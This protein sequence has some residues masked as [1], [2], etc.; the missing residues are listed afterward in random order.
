MAFSKLRSPALRFRKLQPLPFVRRFS[1]SSPEE[2]AAERRRRRSLL[3]MPPP[4]PLGDIPAPPPPGRHSAVK[5]KVNPN[6]PNLPDSDAAL[7]GARLLFHNNILT[8]IRSGDLQEADLLVRHSIYSNCRP[9]IFT[10]NTVLS[11]LLR[12][13]L[14]SEFLSLHRFVNQAGIAPTVFT[15]NLVMQCYIDRSQLDL[16]VDHYRFFCRSLPLLPSPTTY[17]VLVK[18]LVEASRLEEALQLKEEMIGTIDPDPCVY[19]LLMD[20]L[21]DNGDPDRALA[22]YD[23]LKEKLSN[24][25]PK[26]LVGIVNGSL[27]RAH[28]KKGDEGK[29]MQVY[30]SVLGDGSKFK[31]SAQ[32][33]N[34]ILN[35]LNKNGKFEEALALFDRMMGEHCPP[36]RLAMDLESFNIMVDGYCDAG[37]FKEAIEVFSKMREKNCMSDAFSYNNLIKQLGK[38]GMVAEAVELYREMRESGIKPNESTFVF[39]MEAF[40]VADRV[41]DAT[42]YLDEMVEVGVD[43]GTSA[44]NAAFSGLVNAGKLYEAKGYF[45]RMMEKGVKPNLMSYEVLLQAFCEAGR[46]DYVLVVVRG[47]TM[48]D[49]VVFG[50]QLR[51]LVEFTARREQREEELARLYDE[52]K[53]EKEDAMAKAAE[54]KSRE[55]ALAREERLRKRAEAKAKQAAT[56]KITKEHIEMHIKSSLLNMNKREDA[57]HLAGISFNEGPLKHYTNNYFTSQEF[58]VSNDVTDEK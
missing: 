8:L 15:H 1:F 52:V 46:F 55:E 4:S 12:Q 39:L 50:P 23:E 28:F 13:S 34:F 11:A 17:R 51:E 31:F 30:N 41:E 22:L 18:A 33:Y 54:E 56:T 10:V 58:K 29:A 26:S 14:H 36:R 19:S 16:A 40:F 27:I 37:K 2:A 32:S 48:D 25:D 38:T 20:G 21:I 57:P 42:R 47:I 24:D 53:K 5:P 35:A 45:D 3:G 7:T 44:Y 49:G 43:P 9:T 6:I